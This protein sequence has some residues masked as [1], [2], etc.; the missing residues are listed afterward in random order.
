[1][2]TL[3]ASLAGLS[4]Q[5]E[6]IAISPEGVRASA[7]DIAYDAEGTAWLLW[8]QKGARIPGAGH[9][10]A[11]DLYLTRWPADAPPEAPIKVNADKGQVR[12]SALSR[13]RIAIDS[14]G[15]VHALYPV[16]DVSPIHGKPVINI[17]YQSLSAG[18][19]PIQ[20]NTPADN[21]LSSTSHSNVG[22]AATFLS[23][24]A[25]PDNDLYALW[26]DSRHSEF[27][28]SNS[29]VYG[30]RST[31]NGT[32]WSKDT[33]LFEQVCPC[34]QPDTVWSDNQLLVSSRQVDTESHRDPHIHRVAAD[35]ASTETAVR[36]GNGRWQL[37]GCPLKRI[38]VAAGGEQEY[39]AWYAEMETPKGVWLGRRGTQD[40]SF[41]NYTPLHPDAAVSDAPATAAHGTSLWVV[42]H[43][44]TEDAGRGIY[45]STS[46]D[47]GAS[48]SPPERLS[49]LDGTAAFPA[50]ALNER[51]AII[52]WETG[53]QI[54]AMRRARTQTVA[55]H[56]Q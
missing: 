25:G 5:A 8:V 7:V 19:D 39:V 35:L 41:G 12:A 50:I 51:E 14:A 29:W 21:D 47:G 9:A 37:E 56:E 52:G 20:L 33:P 13:A 43:A 18:A 24:S 28:E 11:D 26:I 3:L 44:K 36:V 40:K 42:W 2:I 55:Q 45:L 54:V 32:S 34:C 27:T 10:S 53:G 46:D 23:L 22:S 48:L 4:A 49:E 1:M 15:G 17:C 16:A 38:S 30:A 31:D 6:P